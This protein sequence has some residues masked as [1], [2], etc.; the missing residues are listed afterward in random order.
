MGAVNQYGKAPDADML[1]LVFM[2]TGQIDP[3]F[4]RCSTYKTLYFH[5]NPPVR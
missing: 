1:F 2:Y 3:V 4:V 5:S